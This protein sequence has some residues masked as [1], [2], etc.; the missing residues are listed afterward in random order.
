VLG[1]NGRKSSF[2]LSQE[3]LYITSN[4]TDVCVIDVWTLEQHHEELSLYRYF[5]L[6]KMA[7]REAQSNTH[8]HDVVVRIPSISDDPCK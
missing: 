3:Y 2:F 7:A 8:G 1:F 6:P 4:A 5:E